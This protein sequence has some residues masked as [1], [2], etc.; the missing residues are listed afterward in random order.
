MIY[1]INHKGRCKHISPCIDAAIKI[2]QIVNSILFFKSGFNKHCGKYYQ[3]CK[4]KH[5]KLSI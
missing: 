3:T 5:S 2:N 1:I 4:H